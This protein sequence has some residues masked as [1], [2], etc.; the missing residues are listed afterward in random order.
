MSLEEYLAGQYVRDMQDLEAIETLLIE[1]AET[2]RDTFDDA[3]DSWP[4]QITPPPSSA[5]P[6]YS[7]GT[8]SMLLT[9]V[10]KFIDEYK[11][12]SGKSPN[13]LSRLDQSTRK[14]LEENFRL[15]RKKLIDTLETDGMVKS[16]TFGANNP[17]T[18][19]Q[20]LEFA[21]SHENGNEVLEAISSHEEKDKDDNLKKNVTTWY[22][23]FC[24]SGRLTVTVSNKQEGTDLTGYSWS[25]ESCFLALRLL[26]SMN[27]HLNANLNP[28]PQIRKF[29]EAK[30][31]EQLSFSS[32]P[33]SRFDPAELAF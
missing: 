28:K 8:V 9:A 7:A 19:S 3:S 21:S 31:H 4:Y 15:A 22:E 26:K 24:E 17:V 32:I 14:A 25:S 10:A 2:F 29:F 30:L 5:T 23:G 27:W 6:S 13:S 33:D 18:I 16:R 1:V 20:I 12:P 11:E